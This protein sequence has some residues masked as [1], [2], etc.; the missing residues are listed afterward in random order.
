MRLANVRG[1]G[2]LAAPVSGNTK[3]VAAGGLSIAASGPLDVYE[4]VAP[5]LRTIGK[6]VTYVGAGDVARLVKICRN[7]FLGVATPV[8]GR[9]HRPRGEGGVSR[10]AFLDFS[11]TASWVRS[12]LAT[13]PS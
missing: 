12:S 5:L 1:G 6:S 11:T 7:L 9:G 2:F 3:V 10:A 13:R 4:R 8:D